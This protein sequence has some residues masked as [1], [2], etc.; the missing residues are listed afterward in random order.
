MQ[1]FILSSLLKQEKVHLE[2]EGLIA[3]KTSLDQSLNDQTSF[4]I[5]PQKFMLLLETVR[6]LLLCK[7]YV[8]TG[9]NVG[10]QITTLQR[11]KINF[12]N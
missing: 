10:K 12:S 7:R 8:V 5:Q 11:R 9:T 6:T 2:L 3:Q 1:I 4:N